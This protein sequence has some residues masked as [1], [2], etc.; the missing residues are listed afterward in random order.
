MAAKPS[1]ELTQRYIDTHWGL[2]TSRVR[3]IDDSR[4]PAELCAMGQLLG[5]ILK[6]R[7]GESELNFTAKSDCTLVFDL[8][9]SQT[10]YCILGRSAQREL[11]AMY[12]EIDEPTI[13]L[14]R[15]SKEVGGRQASFRCPSVHVKPLGEV[16]QVYYKTN[17]KGDGMST[18]V[19]TF[20]EEGG[21]FPML[22]VAKDGT[23]WL[24]GGSYHVPDGGITN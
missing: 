11:K 23:I 6:D 22:G 1:K 20:A 13:P 7:E 3:D 18:Y 4:L 24:A 5:F 15:L 12:K 2:S 9:K 19:H 21:V 10:L 8:K 16:Y 14:G 17:K